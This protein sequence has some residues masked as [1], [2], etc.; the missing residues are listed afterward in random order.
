MTGLVLLMGWWLTLLMTLLLDMGL[1]NLEQYGLVGGL[2]HL[3]QPIEVGE[4]LHH[5]KGSGWGVY[6]LLV[7]G[8]YFLHQLTFAFCLD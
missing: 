8:F 1:V 6:L 5:V 7:Q 4:L 2:G 3:A